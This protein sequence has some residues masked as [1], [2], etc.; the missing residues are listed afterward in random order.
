MTAQAVSF[1]RVHLRYASGGGR[2]AAKWAMTH[3]PVQK[4]SIRLP[5]VVW[6]YRKPCTL[7][8][9]STYGGFGTAYCWW[10]TIAEVDE[11]ERRI[12]AQ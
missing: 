6:A 7:C 2:G 3:L 5:P 10:T 4:R 12:A 9:K 1:D 11:L 8:A